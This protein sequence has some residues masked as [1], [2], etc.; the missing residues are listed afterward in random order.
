MKLPAYLTGGIARIDSERDVEKD[1]E[2]R[3]RAE[4]LGF[5]NL[6]LFCIVLGFDCVKQLLFFVHLHCY[7]HRYDTEELDA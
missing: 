2:K 7:I 1:A 3:R 4:N 5:L 6:D